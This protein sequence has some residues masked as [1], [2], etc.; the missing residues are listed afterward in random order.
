MA[1]HKP[2]KRKNRKVKQPQFRKKRFRC[3]WGV[4]G[5]ILTYG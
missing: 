5:E 1:N 4:V 2:M 3:W